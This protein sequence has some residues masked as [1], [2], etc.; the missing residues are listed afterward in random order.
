MIGNG[1]LHISQL[2]LLLTM[3]DVNSLSHDDFQEACA[4]FL[5]NY[6]WTISP[7]N[8][9]RPIKSVVLPTF[10]SFLFFN[11]LY[12]SRLILPVTYSRKQG[13][14]CPLKVIFGSSQFFALDLT[15]PQ[16]HG[17]D[18]NFFS[19]HHQYYPYPYSDSDFEASFYVKRHSPILH[20]AKIGVTTFLFLFF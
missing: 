1:F 17:F 2:L 8:R 7:G 12:F 9:Q 19:I 4:K 6:F 16:R 11:L 14:R 3:S 13:G 5:T 20:A 18:P 15:Q 10:S